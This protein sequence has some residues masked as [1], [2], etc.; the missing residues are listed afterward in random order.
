M[1]LRPLVFLL[2]TSL[3]V[4]AVSAS[5][6]EIRVAALA[7]PGTAQYT[8]AWK[9]KELVEARSAGRFTVAIDPAGTPLRDSEAI[10]Q[11]RSGRLHIG[12]I[13]AGSLEG[14]LPTA[15]VL[16]FP[17][18]FATGAE[19][20]Q[21]LDGPLG[22]T[23]LRDTEAIG[24]KGLGFT[25]GGFRH[26]TNSI[27]PVRT[28][29]DLRD[30]K[31]RVTTSPVQT[32]F[33][34]ALG[35]RP[36]PGPWPMYADLE[37]GVLEG[38]DNPLRIVEA[39]GFDEVQQY[40]S[41]TR[42]SY[43]AYLNL[44]SLHWWSALSP[45]DQLLLESAMTEAGRFQRLDQRVRDAA[46]VPVLMSR[47]MQVEE[48]PDLASF[49]ER[50]AGL[51]DLIYFRDPRVQTLLSRM[52]AAAAISSPPAE[53]KPALAAPPKD[54]LAVEAEATAHQP[55]TEPAAVEPAPLDTPTAVDPFLI[56]SAP[57]SPPTAEIP[58]APEPESPVVV[59]PDPPAEAVSPPPPV[60]PKMPEQ[61]VHPG[62]DSEGGDAPIIEERIP[63]S[64]TLP[65][66]GA[67]AAPETP[68]PPAQPVDI[69]ATGTRG[70]PKQP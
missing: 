47:G 54:E 27:R 68:E 30:L 4:L 31:I 42:H 58:L 22:A 55:M 21:V 51:R 65:A 45:E 18:L 70:P 46:R 62:W 37:A 3:L 36:T 52:Q 33:W 39:Y 17:Y 40:L 57:P 32:A 41:L 16:S 26:L 23:I 49:Q 13:A 24:C 5:A 14:L 28:A 12:I 11:L 6:D 34:S 50:S 66:S 61:I 10:E 48:S 38:Q 60:P 63:P 9:F 15:R 44:A 56:E 43:I 35:A 7:R 69:G 67:P 2:V 19:A 64:P 1:R 20:D 29:D 25:E 59:F 53:A 8:L